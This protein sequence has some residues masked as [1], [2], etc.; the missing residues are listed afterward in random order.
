MPDMPLDLAPFSLLAAGEPWLITWLTPVWILSVGTALGLLVAFVAGMAYSLLTPKGEASAGSIVREG[1]LWPI[2][3]VALALAS[4]SIPGSFI[5]HDPIGILASA[6]RELMT[7][8]QDYEFTIDSGQQTVSFSSLRRSE[9]SELEMFAKS[10]L[11]V[12][13]VAPEEATEFNTFLV[14]GSEDDSKTLHYRTSN[15]NETSNSETPFPEEEFNHLHVENRSADLVTL[16]L[17]ITTQPV[18]PEA[19]TIPYLAISVFGLFFI[20]FLQQRLAP[21]L[22]A[23]ALATAK[24]EMAQPLFMILLALGTFLLFIFIFLPYN[25]FGEDIKVLKD[26]SLSLIMVFSIA[27]AVWSASNSIADEIEGKTALTVLSKPIGRWQF[28]V[29]KLLGIVWTVLVVFI[30]LG[31]VCLICVAYKPV[32][33]A[34]ESGAEGLVWQQCSSE[35]MQLVPGLILAFFE[36]VI[37]AAISVAISTRLPMLANIVIC[38]SIYVLGHITPLIALSTDKTFEGV[39]FIGTLLA[40]VFPVLDH[41]N[42][43]PAIASG[44]PVPP[45]YLLLSFVYCLLYTTIA[46]LLGLTLFEDRDLT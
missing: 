4:F 28:I 18:Y 11:T 2:L 13:T 31:V 12:T 41:F 21:K 35:M 19:G 14:I 40:T 26:S 29:G 15:N 45:E 7:G 3:L 38:L 33:D 34:R 44:V 32:F 42:I 46:M 5:V 22:S 16:K 10:D 23:I 36:A 37:M 1:A 27:L 8:E 9:L 6:P 24:S 43:Q 25:T 17:T 39:A 30:V 20:Y